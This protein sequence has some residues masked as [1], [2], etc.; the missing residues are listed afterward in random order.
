MTDI[1]VK[2]C[3]N[4]LNVTTYNSFVQKLL[5]QVAN[6]LWLDWNIFFIDRLVQIIGAAQS[7]SHE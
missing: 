6:P 5:P 7:M 1:T 3:E 2:D 4:G